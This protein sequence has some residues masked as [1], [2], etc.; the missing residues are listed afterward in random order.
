MAGLSAL[1]NR[2]VEGLGSPGFIG[3]VLICKKD[4]KMPALVSYNFFHV[5]FKNSMPASPCP[6]LWWLYGADT[7]YCMPSLLKKFLNF[8]WNKA[9]AHIQKHLTGQ[10]I[11]WKDN[12]A[13]FIRL[14]AVHPMTCFP[15]GN[16]LW[17]S[18]IQR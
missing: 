11:F 10:P 13:C 8:F 6:L 14:A 12:F 3:V 7:M 2:S 1:D 15:T 17:S 4:I 9:C 18:T 16:L 5:L